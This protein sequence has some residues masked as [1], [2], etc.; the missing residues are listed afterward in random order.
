MKPL[1]KYFAASLMLALAVLWSGGAAAQNLDTSAPLLFTADTLTHD[2]A[3][4]IVTA[5]GNVEIT[6]K[7]RT[8]LADTISYNERENIVSASGHVTLM[9]PSGDVL[10]AEF[11]ELT[12]DFK[13]GIIRGLRIRLSDN[14]RIA[15]SGAR[16]SAGLRT[17]M[18]NAVY[19]PCDKCA[20]E[21]GEPP[22]WQIKAARIVH[23]Q[24]EQIIEYNDAWME[25]AGIPVI[26]TPYF[27][28]P[29]PTVKRKTGF[30]APKV[31]GSTSL[32]TS[33]S[34]PYFFAISP[35]RDVTITP[36]LMA[37][38]RLLLEGEYRQLQSDQLIEARGSVTYDSQNEVR[39]HVN[40]FT[41]QDVNDTWR[42][43]ADIKRSTDDTYLRR[44]RISSESSLNS[45]LFAEAFRG[46]DYASAD[47]YL[48]QGLRET[49]NNG[50][51]PIVFPMLELNHISEPGKFGE[52]TSM[53][54]S[55]LVLTRTNGTD[56]RRLSLGGSVAKPLYGLFGDVIEISAALRGDLYHYASHP[57]EGE[58][59]GFDT[60]FEGRA[61]PL[62][63]ASW[64]LPLTRRHGAN[65]TEILEPSVAVFASPNMGNSSTIPN[66]DSIEQEFD[67]TNLFSSNKF[68]GLDRV[69]SSTRI[70]YGLRWGVHGA[71]GGAS[72]FFV[73]QRYRIRK[74][75]SFPDGSGLE[76]YFSDIVARVRVQPNSNLALAYKT[77]IDKEDLSPRRTELDL[78]AGA[79][80]LNL[81]TNYVFFDRQENSE[82]GGR[83]ELSGQVTAKLDRLWRASFSSRY[84]L[85]GDGDLR[86]VGLNFTYECECFIFNISLQRHFYEDRDLKPSDSIFFRLTFKTLGEIQTGIS[87]SG[88]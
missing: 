75:D 32:G 23:D 16:R 64:R 38:E 50:T 25:I 22:L 76:D 17:E 8:L 72:S 26:Y 53:D 71:K 77:R 20:S 11:M 84:D 70:S 87:Q 21:S 35:N 74:D 85:Q 68:T 36:T 69:E 44:Y 28:H 27:S 86:S 67:E 78:T 46:R 65:I 80:A 56:T 29:D 63:S 14:A 33:I 55:L 40:S 54:A 41:R 82:F 5:T 7:D 18:R 10:F 4:G 81:R 39:G 2:R 73:G 57:I 6:Q 60:G 12:S 42:W 24:E 48:F 43:G 45:R 58:E 3:L 13:D 61:Y 79:P 59:G 88:S 19:S 83:E 15:A 31:G 37:K 30:L 1:L 66:E 34:T 62:L 47:A 49:D 52:T 9:E 51:T